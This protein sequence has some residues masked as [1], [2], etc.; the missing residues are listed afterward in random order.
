M[1]SDHERLGAHL[2]ELSPLE[3]IVVVEVIVGVL[4]YMLAHA[5]CWTWCACVFLIHLAAAVALGI[6]IELSWTEGPDDD[7]PL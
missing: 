2:D 3:A 1:G 5:V 7:L 4:A 6:I